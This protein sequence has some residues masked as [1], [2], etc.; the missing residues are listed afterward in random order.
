[1]SGRHPLALTGLA[2]VFGQWGK[3]SP[4]NALHRELLER[5]FHTYVAC[6]H[7]AL[8]AEAAGHHEE[9]VAFAERAWDDREPAF[10]LWARHFPPYRRLHADPRVAAILREMDSPEGRS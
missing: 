3:P 8:T 4:A 1:M 5:S 6:A 9:A 10:I 7:L 2:T